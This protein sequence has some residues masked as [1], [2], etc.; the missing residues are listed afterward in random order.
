MRKRD[1]T[2][3][4]WRH[5]L[6]RRKRPSHSTVAAYLALF[7]ALGGGSFAVATLS[8]GEKRVVKKIAKKEANKR[9]A[10][11]VPGFDLTDP[12]DGTTPKKRIGNLEIQQFC[13][14]V[15]PGGTSGVIF[16]NRGPATAT[17]NWLYSDG[18][19][20]LADGQFLAPSGGNRQF[21]FLDR[22]IEGQ[23]IFSSPS[24][25]VTVSLH[26]FDAG[27]YCEVHGTA[28]HAPSS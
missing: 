5:R 9:I 26:A 8:G 12:V 21:D 27:P 14:G 13:F 25:K 6:A 23:F 18:T 2:R 24:G 1:E 20:V 4:H 28:Q 16:W 3:D 11:R 15:G 22:R 19:T 10:Q 7:L 17:L